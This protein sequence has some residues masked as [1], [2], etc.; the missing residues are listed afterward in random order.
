MHRSHI[1][2]YRICDHG[3]V[4]VIDR[5]GAEVVNISAHYTEVPRDRSALHLE[6]CLDVFR[7]GDGQIVWSASA[8]GQDIAAAGSLALL[9]NLVIADASGCAVPR[10]L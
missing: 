8:N 6:T 7:N 10:S 3:D 5:R 2:S 4:E 9:L 1:R